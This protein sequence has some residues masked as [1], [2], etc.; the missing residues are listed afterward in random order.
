MWFLGIFSHGRIPSETAEK[1]TEFIKLEKRM[2]EEWEFRNEQLWFIYSSWKI[3]NCRVCENT[4]T[5][6]L[7]L[8]SN[9]AVDNISTF[10]WYHCVLWFHPLTSSCS[11]QGKICQ[12]QKW[13]ANLIWLPADCSV[14]YTDLYICLGDCHHSVY[15]SSLEISGFLGEFW[16]PSTAAVD[17]TW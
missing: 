3:Y 11:Y 7:G 8:N 12:H 17:L 5:N 4:W 16:L 2:K 14:L 15:R 6:I 9:L 13:K 1:K 10:T